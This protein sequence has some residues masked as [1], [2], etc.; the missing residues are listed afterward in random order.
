MFFS[1][2]ARW[3]PKSYKRSC[4]LQFFGRKINGW[5]VG[6]PPCGNSAGDLF[7]VGPWGCQVQLTGD[8]ITEKRTS[9]HICWGEG[10][11]W[12]GMFLGSKY[13]TLEDGSGIYWY[14]IGYV[15]S[16]PDLTKKTRIP[17]SFDTSKWHE[18]TEGADCHALVFKTARSIKGKPMA[19]PW[20]AIYF[21]AVGLRLTSY[22]IFARPRGWKVKDSMNFNLKF[23]QL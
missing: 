8:W 3:A 18:A 10:F 11:C 14:V 4:K 6:G 7:G 23:K 15:G 17:N 21:W 5:L 16:P 19:K 22:D 9:S 2:L 1:K 12:I 13:R 20:E